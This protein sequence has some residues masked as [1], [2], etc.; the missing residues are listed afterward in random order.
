MLA[1]AALQDTMSPLPFFAT[2]SLPVWKKPRPKL[3]LAA[4]PGLA[5]KPGKAWRRSIA[6]AAK[7]DSK[8]PGA[9][10]RPSL[11][12]SRS[13]FYVVPR[14][15]PVPAVEELPEVVVEE[16]VE[17]AEERRLLMACPEITF[18]EVYSEDV[19]KGS[20]KVSN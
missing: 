6:V 2:P 10:P 4:S 5:A 20:V 18:N 19:M 9:A 8:V 11:A 3:E 13:S 7:A 12:A 17:D 16:E 14:P 1:L 15:L